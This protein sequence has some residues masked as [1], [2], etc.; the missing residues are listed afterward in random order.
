METFVYP[1]HVDDLD[2]QAYLEPAN[3]TAK[4]LPRVIRRDFEDERMSS[5]WSI[6][7]RE[8]LTWWAG[9]RD[10]TIARSHLGA[11]LVRAVA[12]VYR[13]G[14]HR[15]SVWCI[16]DGYEL[17]GLMIPARLTLAI[18][19]DLARSQDSEGLVWAAQVMAMPGVYFLGGSELFGGES[20]RRHGLLNW[21]TDRPD[22]ARDIFASARWLLALTDQDSY[23]TRFREL[24]EPFR[25][26]RRAMP[27]W[28]RENSPFTDENY[29]ALAVHYLILRA[30]R[31]PLEDGKRAEPNDVLGMSLGKSANSARNYVDQAVEAGVL[32]GGARRRYLTVKGDDLA[33]ELMMSE[34]SA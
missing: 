10:G 27:D 30:L 17:N 18:G 31:T 3:V 5:D 16:A 24:L 11:P 26:D 12:F 29:A 2:H 13:G 14:D 20:A 19:G 4:R 32:T 9:N 8:P 6:N 25:V 33:A 28:E 21:D 1:W 34:L 15:Q 7:G 23:P 22:T